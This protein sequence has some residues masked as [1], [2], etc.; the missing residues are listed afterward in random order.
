MR[1]ANRDTRIANHVIWIFPLNHLYL[2]SHF[3]KALSLNM[4]IFQTI[5]NKL[6]GIIAIFIGL[7]LGL[8]VLE[9]AVN[10]NTNLLKGNKD[11]VGV[12]DGNAIHRR[13]FEN[14]VDEAVSNYKLQT[15]QTNVDDNTMFSLRD[16]TW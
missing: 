10:S 12:I 15:S 8:F 9:T 11:V 2:Q 16:Q 13:D 5:R 6:G 4:A 7:A 1:I 3:L 14:R